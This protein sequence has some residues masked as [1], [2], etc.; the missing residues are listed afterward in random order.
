MTLQSVYRD[1]VLRL[2]II[3]QNENRAPKGPRL[4]SDNFELLNA[5]VLLNLDVICCPA[6][7]S[8]YKVQSKLYR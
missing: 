1:S 6:N 3:G 5:A 7:P 8:V 4:Y 2:E